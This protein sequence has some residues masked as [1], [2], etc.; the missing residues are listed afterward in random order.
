[1]MK[2]V[3]SVTI[4]DDAVGTRISLTYSE[5]SDDG[6]I[7]ADNKRLD[8][9]ITDSDALSAAA[10]LKSYAQAYTDKAE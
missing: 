10:S 4:F 8:R 6:K 1:M 7:T 2:K 5:I 9:V 3:T